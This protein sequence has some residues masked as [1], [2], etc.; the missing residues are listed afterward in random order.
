M[1]LS[2]TVAA[3]AAG[4][5][6]ASSTLLAGSAAMAA[7]API[8]IT[9]DDLGTTVG[10]T[11]TAWT[12]ANNEGYLTGRYEIVPDADER[13]LL[14][15]ETLPGV[16]EGTQVKLMHYFDSGAYPA[17]DDAAT[18]VGDDERASVP[19]AE[20]LDLEFSVEYRETYL[21][22][23]FEMWYDD[24]GYTTLRQT[25]EASA[26]WATAGVNPEGWW[27]TSRELTDA[28]GERLE[29]CGEDGDD[30]CAA[31]NEHVNLGVLL[32]ALE[33]QNP[34]VF[35]IG[36]NKGRDE[37][38]ERA[39]LVE[40]RSL[41]LLG[42]DFVFGLSPAAPADPPAEDSEE[43]AELIDDQ[44]IDVPASTE[45]FVPTGSVNTDL[46][47]IDPEKPLNGVYEN[48]QDPTDFFVDVYSYSAAKFVGTFPIVDGDA[49]LSDLDLSHLAAGPHFL[50]LQGQ[51]SGTLGVVQLR[52]LD[53]LPAT[54]APLGT[55][56]FALAGG[57]LLLG[58][59]AFLAA[60][61]SRRSY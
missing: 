5:L 28:G 33:D 34:R 43:L 52:V 61:R 49:V 54:G 30:A 18:V 6:V 53:T 13:A 50:V 9:Q 42:Q 22:L 16:E 20:L 60:R 15:I 27:T 58:A 48:W 8:V 39:G 55:L 19:L 47:D 57:L 59:A 56:P 44:D 23:Q 24:G 51:T 46:Q 17:I 40:V 36:I 45:R 21:S 12:L 29:V 11:T 4:V 26:D 31:N 25:A 37:S 2:R 14:E 32:E 10:D 1:K 3:G 41:S 38:A 35:S 7:D